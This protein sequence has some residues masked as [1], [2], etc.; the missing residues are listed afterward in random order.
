VGRYPV[1][2][3][4]S[5]A[6]IRRLANLVVVARPAFTAAVLAYPDTNMKQPMA[7][8]YDAERQALGV[9]IWYL[10]G[11]TATLRYAY[12]G[13]SWQ[14]PLV[15]PANNTFALAVAADGADWIAGANVDV[16]NLD[17]VSLAVLAT[18]RSPISVAIP[19]V[20]FDTA[21]ASDGT[22]AV[23]I[24]LVGNCDS[25]MMF[26]NPRN[27]SYTQPAY[28][29]CRARVG[30]SADGSRL[31][32]IDQTTQFSGG[33]VYLADT[34][35]GTLID[36][37]LQAVSSFEPVLDRAGDRIAINLDQSTTPH[38]EIYDGSYTALGTLPT[39]T[40]AVMLSPDGHKAY[41]YDQSGLL[42]TYDLT[43]GPV[44]GVFPQIGTG[45]TLAGSPGS[46]VPPGAGFGSNSQPFRMAITPDGATVFIAGT[47]AVVVQ[48]IP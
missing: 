22:V 48:P 46:S 27:L 20:V 15:K 13:T 28:T 7:M 10:S 43:A 39:T 19:Q 1:V 40:V 8:I 35:A 42:R 11:Q 24:V 5:Y 37:G 2:L 17:P 41:G 45:I 44:A 33:D 32:V 31:L 9:T 6:A 47:D 26:Y 29:P 25:N 21:V 23:T 34:T 12:N 30:A 38:W 18:P 36:T 16:A 4:S 14:S 3:Q